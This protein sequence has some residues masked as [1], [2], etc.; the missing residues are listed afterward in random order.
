MTARRPLLASTALLA[1]LALAIVPVTPAAAAPG[2]D[3][4]ADAVDVGLGWTV[5]DLVDATLEPGEP[6]T[7]VEHDP[8]FS[9]YFYPAASS[10]W[11]RFT[12]PT[13]QTIRGSITD[14]HAQTGV[15]HVY[16]GASLGALSSVTCG[17]GN[18][19]PG[20]A[21]Q[22]AAGQT[23]YIQV[24]ALD[25]GDGLIPE[26]TLFLSALPPIPNTTPAGAITLA[27]PS[28]TTAD[29]FGTDAELVAPYGCSPE[30]RA[31]M[32]DLFYRFTAPATGVVTI[33][34]SASDFAVDFAVYPYALPPGDPIAC[35]WPGSSGHEP[36]PGTATA[37][38]T[39]PVTAGASYLIQVGGFYLGLGTVS[40]S[41]S[42]PPS[43]P[44]AVTKVAPL[45]GPRKGG[46]TVTITGTGFT[47][48]STVA[49]GALAAASVT[50]VSPTTLRAVTPRV[51]SAR[52]VEVYVTTPAGTSP[53]A[54]LAKFLYLG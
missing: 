49:F 28:T 24:G 34:A 11:Y 21:F 25:D 36:Y 17:D 4:F 1:A 12:S 43:T 2:N 48:D 51:P 54:L 5:V 20:F 7:C 18:D 46:T 47:P 52:L 40:L 22:A 41:L 42:Q 39:I 27:V 14:Y 3:D 29:T 8:D 50:Y 45:I 32:N 13:A 26:A 15:V 19:R 53:K 31:I 23:F 16:T 33:D 9:S 30:D 35:P 38:T 10:V 44:P 37:I 6:T